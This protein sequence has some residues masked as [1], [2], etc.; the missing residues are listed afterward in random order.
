MPLHFARK[1]SSSVPRVEAADDVGEDHVRKVVISNEE[2]SRKRKL[3]D[4][5]GH[6]ILEGD[7]QDLVKEYPLSHPFYD[8]VKRANAMHADS[9][10][11]STRYRLRF[12]RPDGK[13]VDEV[14]IP[15]FDMTVYMVLERVCATYYPDEPASA[16][17]SILSDYGNRDQVMRVL[18]YMVTNH[19]IGIETPR[20]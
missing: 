4:I 2:A 14:G 19:K 10:S 1:R 20:N 9:G 3:A 8:L 11:F 17:Y 7:V 6:V 5:A 16:V 18:Q 13:T 15:R 12:K